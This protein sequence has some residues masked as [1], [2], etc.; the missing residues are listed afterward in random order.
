MHSPM[1]LLILTLLTCTSSTL[2][3]HATDAAPTT[4]HLTPAQDETLN[5]RGLLSFL[6]PKVSAASSP[7]NDASPN[8]YD[9]DPYDG[10]NIIVYGDDGT[11][12]ASKMVDGSTPMSFGLSWPSTSDA[13]LATT[14][15][16]PANNQPQAVQTGG[17]SSSTGGGVYNATTTGATGI[18]SVV[19]E[20]INSATATS[21]ADVADGDSIFV[22]AAGGGIDAMLAG[23]TMALVMLGAVAVY[24]L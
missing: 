10:S 16:D 15:T 21:T 19:T 17:S 23:S 18:L 24:L 3:E 12:Y 7:F 14:A 8:S 11:I 5:K 22:G 13:F 2:A 20:A 9:S 6:K 1:T 4:T